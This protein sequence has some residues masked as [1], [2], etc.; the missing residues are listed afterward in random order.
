[1]AFAAFWAIARSVEEYRQV[2][3]AGEIVSFTDRVMAGVTSA[4]VAGLYL[5]AWWMACRA[6]A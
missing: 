3:A 5:P 1:V 4:V 2:S 6:M